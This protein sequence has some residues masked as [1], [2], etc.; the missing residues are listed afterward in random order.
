M[1]YFD[2]AASG[3]PKPAE[4][5]Q[6]VLH[7]M[8]HVG[9]N[10]GRSGHQLAVEG[11]RIVYETREGL[12]EL[13]GVSDPLRIVFGPNA[14]EALNLA[15]LGLLYHWASRLTGDRAAARLVPPLVFLSGGL[16][17]WM[18]FH[19]TQ[20]LGRGLTGLA[21]LLRR[22]A[23]DYTMFPGALRWGN[24]VLTLLIPQR[25]FLLGLP[26]FL[27]VWTLWWR[28][29]GEE[30]TRENGP[31]QLRLMTGAGVLAGLLPQAHAHSFA[32]LMAS[33]VCLVPLF[34]AF[35]AWVRFF[36][37]AAAVAAP[38]LIYS[39][40]GSS[41]RTGT[42]VAWHL[43]WDRGEQGVAAFWL[44][45]TG[46]VWPL[47]LLALLWRGSR[48]VVPARLAL[49]LSPFVIW[50]IAPNLLRLSPWIWDNIKF[51]FFWYVAATPLVALVVVRIWR[52]PRRLGW[53]PASA[54][55][56]SLILSGALD[57]W[58]IAGRVTAQ[59]IFDAQGL[60]F[61]RLV[62]TVT[63]PRALVLHLPTYNH[64]VY[65]SGRRSLLGYPG[66]IPSQGLDA[67]TR[68]QDVA[69]IYAGDAEASALLAR[70][71]VDY[72]VLGPHERSTLVV[73]EEF[74]KRF[75]WVG[76]VGDYRL[77]KAV[78]RQAAPR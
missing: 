39:A 32:V 45:N 31:R 60:A 17:W 61:A 51:L 76:E 63:P 6:A 65:L 69:R 1:I 43:G 33:A 26:L 48:P 30:P 10:P 38:Q 2:N 36:G 49:F 66:H 15:L 41:V 52:L 23:H 58:R 14:T 24:A 25:A 64:P 54:L 29:L 3:W 11:A 12:A 4:V 40:V 72:I 9:A 19:E 28:A 37:Y 44:Y 42:F 46:L 78:Q 13:L 70:Y 67:G 7:Y 34:P 5:L 27:M 50:F 55:L 47:L 20:G 53:L 57:V 77:Y 73:N 8:E 35:K 75:E 21:E 74:L 62:T 68:E 22:P 59:R 16:G 71:G 18:L 56:L